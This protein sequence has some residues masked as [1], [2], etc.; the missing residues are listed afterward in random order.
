M[1]K[2]RSIIAIVIP[3][4]MVCAATPAVSGNI[5]D[6]GVA[7][8]SIRVTAI[9][10]G[11]SC[12]VT[13]DGG[14]DISLSPVVASTIR[15]IELGSPV[16]EI[17]KTVDVTIEQCGADGQYSLQ[18]TG[19]Q[20]AGYPGAIASDGVA[21]GVAHYLKYLDPTGTFYPDG[22][23]LGDGRQSSGHHMD[24]SG[25]FTFQLEAGYMRVGEPVISGKTTSTVT[26]NVV[27]N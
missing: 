2:T 27:Q 1:M 3:L 5:W 13:V 24:T 22:T 4:M 17:G 15:Q 12:Q 14:P 20:V 8:G 6:T 21:Q 9:V 23:L 26:V 19:E 18:F 16:P 10:V 25:T 11:A 7:S